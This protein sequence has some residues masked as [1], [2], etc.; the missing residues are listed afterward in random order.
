MKVDNMDFHLDGAGASRMRPV[1]RVSDGEKRMRYLLIIFVVLLFVSVCSAQEIAITI[2]DAPRGDT[3]LFSGIKRTQTLIEN[4]RKAK[5]ADVLIFVVTK[6]IDENSIERLEAYE[7]AGFHLANHSH[8]HFSANRQDLDIYLEDI[9]VAHRILEKF[10]SFVPFYRYPYLHHGNNR[11]TRDRIQAH[12]KNLEYGIGYVTID[13]YEWYM[14]SLLQNALSEG[15][16]VDY[17]ALGNVYIAT[18]WETIIFYDTIA[19]RTLG[20]SP[21]HVL[22]VHENDITALYIG[23]LAEYIRSQGWK[24]ISPQE[25][26]T[27]PIVSIVSDVLYNN[28]G[29]VAAIARGQGWERRRLSHEA[30]NEVYLKALFERQNVFK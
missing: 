20:P 16:E 30:E 21:K 29:R 26:Y 27:D 7:E 15:K 6:Q 24:I 3:K 22:L 18:L 13:N 9:T 28:Q 11:E 5:V 14:D 10:D 19:R 17:E 23:E 25:A 1:C 4:L 2:D 12:L 8:N